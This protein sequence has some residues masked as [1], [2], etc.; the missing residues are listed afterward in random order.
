MRVNK[1]NK[2]VDLEV[3]DWNYLLPAYVRQYMFLNKNEP[4][5]K[6]VIPMVPSTP[7]PTK[8]G[9]TIPVIF[10]AIDSAIAMEIAQDGSNIPEAT[11]AEIAQ[12]DEKEDEIKRLKAQV[13]ALTGPTI[14]VSDVSIESAPEEPEA[15]KSPAQ[16]AFAK[17]PQATAREPKLPDTVI[18]PGSSLDGMTPRDRRDQGRVAKDLRSEPEI[19]ETEEIP[20]DKEITKDNKGTPTVKD[21]K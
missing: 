6:V 7:H 1:E 5:D 17:Q 12:V 10:V 4:P 21:K 15:T 13:E 8:P 18:P 19:D 9:A 14:D 11:E 3:R 20:F 2:S 16:K